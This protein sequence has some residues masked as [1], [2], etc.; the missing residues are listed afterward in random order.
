MRIIPRALGPSI[1]EATR[2]FPAVVVTGPRRAGKTTLLRRL[3]PKAQ[4]WLLEDPDQQARIRSDPRSFLAGVEPPVIL[5]EMQNTPELFAYI[6]TRI[7]AEP[8]ARGRWLLTGSQ[9]SP[10]MQGVTES[11]AGRA[12]V[13]QLLPLSTAESSKVTPFRGGF[14]EVVA[15]PRSAEVWLRSYV[16]TYLERDVRAV[17]AIRDLATFRRFLGLAASRSGR[18][19]N[20]TD[21]A[22][23]LGVSVPTVG[24][25]LSILEITGQ[26]MMVPPYLDNFGKRLVKTPRLYFCDTGLLCHLLG[27]ESQRQLESSPFL[28][29]VFETFV[30]SEIAKA[31]LAAGRRRE[32][33]YFRDEQGLE[34]DFVVPVPGGRLLLAE[35]KA[36][37]TVTPPMAAPLQR[38]RTAGGDRIAAAM[39]VH[40]QDNSAPRTQALAEGVAAVDLPS[41]LAAIVPKGAPR[42][43][44]AKKRS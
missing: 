1:H 2:D 40:R 28:G 44:I 25:W 36:A 19:L 5:D 23:P 34:V 33:Y 18:M 14:P 24:A 31:Q 3:F 41:L 27:I 8:N 38:L 12:A 42:H 20:K 4:Y 35:A 26:V 16:Q 22:A 43:R 15:R 32:F 30:A 17:T 13:F 11:L 9:E 37:R 21:V 39:L 29:E 10:L 6:R 7:D